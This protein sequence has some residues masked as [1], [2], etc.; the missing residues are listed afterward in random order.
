M[1][2]MM[3]VFKAISMAIGQLAAMLLIL[4]IF[5]LAW[6]GAY[7]FFDG[8]LWRLE[9][10]AKLRHMPSVKTEK[11]SGCL[12]PSATDSSIRRQCTLSQ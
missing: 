1:M 7:F 10:A 8:W 3:L 11:Y 12:V 4:V 2:M 5:M 6:A 9:P